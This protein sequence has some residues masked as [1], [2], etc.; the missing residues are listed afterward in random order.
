MKIPV[1][2]PR[3]N[4]RLSMGFEKFSSELGKLV[5]LIV[6]TSRLESLS[7]SLSSLDSDCRAADCFSEMRNAKRRLRSL[8]LSL[9]KA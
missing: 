8:S 3:M 5:S 1:I 7:N 4:P 2:S 6:S 9:A